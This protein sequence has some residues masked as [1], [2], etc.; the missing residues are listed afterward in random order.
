MPGT[1]PLLG[2]LQNNGGPTDTRALL[3]FSPAI[4]HIPT[5]Y[6][7]VRTDQRGVWRPQG[8]GCD[9]GAFEKKTP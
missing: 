7:A 2:P 1:K 3:P 9:I 6:C 4:N 8:A 5:Q